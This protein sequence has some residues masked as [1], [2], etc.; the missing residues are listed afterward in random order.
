M[1]KVKLATFK[2]IKK[3]IDPNMIVCHLWYRNY[4][5]NLNK[6][7]SLFGHRYCKLFFYF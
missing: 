6:N 7:D 5:F 3:N 1:V 4:W 2:K